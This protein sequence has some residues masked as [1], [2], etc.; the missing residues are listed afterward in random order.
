MSEVKTELEIAV[1]SLK[2]AN[3]LLTKIFNVES[4]EDNA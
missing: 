3:D 2:R 1:E 4:E